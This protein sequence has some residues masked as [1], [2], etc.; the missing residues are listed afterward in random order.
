MVSIAAIVLEIMIMREEE[1]E[2]LTDGMEDIETVLIEI[3]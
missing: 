1:E 2:E 3:E